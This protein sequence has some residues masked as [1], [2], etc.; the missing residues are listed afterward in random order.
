MTRGNEIEKA[1]RVFDDMQVRE[2]PKVL[3]T[4]ITFMILTRACMDD[5]LVTKAAE[6]ASMRDALAQSGA[7]ENDFSKY[8]TRDARNRASAAD[9]D[10]ASSERYANGRFG[11]GGAGSYGVERYGAA[12]DESV[13]DAGRL[14]AG[15]PPR[16]E[17]RR[18]GAE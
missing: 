5:G 1:L 10:F 6:L 14:S 17:G 2:D 18:R 3:P 12:S 13:A 4:E 8:E 9:D 16:D 11:Y 7:L 15:L